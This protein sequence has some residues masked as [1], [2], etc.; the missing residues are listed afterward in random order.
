MKYVGPKNEIAF[1]WF[2][3]ECTKD[4]E[5]NLLKNMKI[6]WENTKIK[7][8][9]GGIEMVVIEGDE[10]QGCPSKNCILLNPYNIFSY[11]KENIIIHGL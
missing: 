10:L 11:N 2:V 9:K 4:N 7:F 3:D 1:L 5:G 8:S 6:L